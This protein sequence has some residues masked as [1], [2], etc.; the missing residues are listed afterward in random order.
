MNCTNTATVAFH[1]C[2]YTS[3]WWQIRDA[4]QSK[5]CFLLS[6]PS[7]KKEKNSHLKPTFQK[8]SSTLRSCVGNASWAWSCPTMGILETF[9]SRF[10]GVVWF[11]GF[12]GVGF[13]ESF[14][15]HLHMESQERFR[16]TNLW[17]AAKACVVPGG[18]S[19]QDAPV[20][21]TERQRKV[22]PKGK[23]VFNL[24]FSYFQWADGKMETL[25]ALWTLTKIQGLQKC[26]LLELRG[27]SSM[28]AMTGERATLQY[29]SNLDSPLH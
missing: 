15:K 21:P 16:N 1:C 24:N 14:Y 18:C 4:L 19:R 25:R 10:L 11:W 29:S 20:T 22:K 23:A 9:S 27:A 28:S 5:C 6:H 12:L 17:S 8:Y 26:W 7:K 2:S 13:S 3:Y